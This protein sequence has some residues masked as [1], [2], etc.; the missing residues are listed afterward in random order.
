MSGKKVEGFFNGQEKKNK[1]KTSV[2]PLVPSLGAKEST[3]APLLAAQNV[4][5]PHAISRL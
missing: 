4:K 1:S 3:D 2:L 5:G